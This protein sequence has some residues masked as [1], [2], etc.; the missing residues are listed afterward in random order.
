ML[1]VFYSKNQSV[2]ANS[3]FSPSAGKPEHVVYSWKECGQAFEIS[4]FDPVTR[5]DLKLVH[6]PGYVDGVLDLTRSNGFGNKSPEVAV[7]LPWVAGSM[8]AATLHAFKNKTVAISPTSGAHHAH[9]RNGGGYCTF[10]FLVLAALK[11]HE[12]GA[13]KVGIIDLDC[14]YGDGTQNIISTLKLDFIKHYTFGGDPLIHQ[15]P[16]LWLKKLPEVVSTFSDCDLII[17]NAGVDSHIDDPL[18]GYLRTEQIEERDSIVL[19][20]MREKFIPTVISLA[21]G[22]QRDE[23]GNISK[24]LELHGFVFNAAWFAEKKIAK[25]LTSNASCSNH[26]SSL[27]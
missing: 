24:V 11:A 17:Y 10:N 16:A 19:N 7:A 2:R 26:N 12:A 27:S 1:K 15:D 23:S 3:S 13:R 20:P 21:G 5:E 22:Y 14:H 4:S 8:V 6:D 25:K 18:G 9:Y